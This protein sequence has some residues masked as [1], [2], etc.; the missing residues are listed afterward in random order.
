M[1]EWLLNSLLC[2]NRWL[3]RSF[4]FI[5]HRIW[6]NAFQNLW[7]VETIFVWTF[8]SAEGFFLSIT[9]HLEIFLTTTFDPI[10]FHLRFFG[11]NPWSSSIKCGSYGSVCNCFSSPRRSSICINH[12]FRKRF[13]C[14]NHW[15]H[16]NFLCFS[17]YVKMLLITIFDTVEV[18]FVQI[19]DWK[20]KGSLCHWFCRRFLSINYWSYIVVC[21]SN[22]SPSKIFFYKSQI[23]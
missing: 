5:N 18:I 8:D 14:I 6:T 12:W 10:E 15:F 2:T 22:L 1:N 17:H 4:H 21:I 9:V 16:I 3:Y 11:L 19:P 23:A 20:G 13:F 7:S